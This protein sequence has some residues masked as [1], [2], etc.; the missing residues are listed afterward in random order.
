MFKKFQ[1]K[2]SRFFSTLR[3][4]NI[5]QKT[6]VFIRKRPL[7]AFLISLGLLFLL[8][9]LG[10]LFKAPVKETP[11]QEIVKE[12]NVL[13]L[14][15]QT[16]VKVSGQVEKQGVLQ[17]LAQSPG[18][19][20]KVS[21]SEGDV[22]TKG[23]S[24]VSLSSNY[25]GGNIASI[26]RQIAQKQFENTRDSFDAQKEIVNKQKDLANQNASNTES[27]RQ[28]SIKANEDANSLLN[29]NEDIF[30][31]IDRTLQELIA[32]NVGGINDQLIL[33]SKQAEAGI[34]AGINQLN[35]QIRQFDYS[36]NTNNPPT[37]IANINLDVTLKQ[38]DIQEKS[39]NLNK[40]VS[41]LQLNLAQVSEAMMF[42]VSPCKGE[43]EKISV[44]KGDLVNPGNPLIT[45]SCSE[46][47]VRVVAKVPS[48]VAKQ[49]SL[50]TESLLN[51]DGEKVYLLPDFVSTEATDGQL[52][53][54]IY[55]LPDYLINQSTNGSFIKVEVPIGEFNSGVQFF[56]PLD[57]VFQTQESAY[58][59]VISDNKAV[60][61]KVTL[62]QVLGSDVEVLSGLNS[63]DVI[64]LNRNV[65]AGEAVRVK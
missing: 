29:L 38:L 9:F 27:L 4:R 33:Q 8:I 42:P 47:D 22:V 15:K 14:G 5:P 63:G 43:V 18:V 52:Y 34:Q 24:L 55:T 51:I 57:S 32:S 16:T 21:V 36:N 39:L 30:H 65:I 62:G 50:I 10:S 3:R 35:S 25:Q 40:E 6:V 31:S 56:I 41:Q 7:T 45:I 48:Q 37:K 54:I 44:V 20:S 53:Q 13:T 1:G 60:S 12:V 64:I 19:V 58:V 61:K 23:Q 2:L 17:I 11:T 26:S 49:A 46:R 59:Y 28:I